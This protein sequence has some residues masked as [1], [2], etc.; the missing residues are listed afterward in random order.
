M[1]ARTLSPIIFTVLLAITAILV[2]CGGGSSPSGSTTAARVN[3]SISDPPTCSSPNGA[4]SHVYITVRDVQ[5]HT[6]SSANPGDS[7]WVDLTPNLKNTPQQIDLLGIANNQCVLS[8]LG[9]QVPLQAGTYQQ[10]RLYVSDDS[11]ASKLTNNQCG[12]NVA[13]CVVLTA[14]GTPQPLNMSSQTQTGIK[15]PP[16][17]IA[18]GA[19]TIGAGQSK[20][21]IIDFDACASII[22]QGNGQV[23]LKPVLHAGEVQLGAAISGKLVDKTTGQPIVGGSSIVALERVDSNGIDRVV[24][25]TKPDTNGN[26]SLCPVP[27]GNYDVVAVA[28]SGSGV[29]YAATI[30]TGVPS[31]TALGNVPMVA[32]TGTNTSNAT[33][34]GQITTMKGTGTTGTATA[35]D[36]NVYAL[37]VVG[38]TSYIIPLADQASPSSTVGL[39]TASA[40]TCPANTD[41]ATYTLKVPAMWP[42]IGAFSSSGTSYSQSSTTPVGYSI[43]ADA[44][45]PASNAVS[46]CSPS[47]IIVNTNNANPA[48][49]LTVAAGQ[50]STA[51]TIGFS[52]CQ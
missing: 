35:A 28:V 45:V 18:G 12:S 14:G 19:F 31:G 34:T 44:F 33:I 32:Q 15:I 23:R 52:N 25:Q 16:G 13:N 41:C 29:A 48:G 40:Q 36:I 5:I 39:T 26:F 37:Q 17:Q 10:I 24:M 4:F 7:G 43:G 38:S 51:A 46:N 20:D 11:D 9:S 21:L 50:S 22:M 3:I 6:S 27:L 42:N 47:E 2:A 1:R 49:P 8:L 30:A